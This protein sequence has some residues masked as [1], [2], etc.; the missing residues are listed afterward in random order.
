MRRCG[1]RRRGSGKI[2]MT[3]LPRRVNRGGAKKIT[4]LQSWV[5]RRGGGGR[6]TGAVRNVHRTSCDTRRGD[7]WAIYHRAGHILSAISSLSPGYKLTRPGHD[8]RA[9]GVRLR[10]FCIFVTDHTHTM[11]RARRRFFNRGNLRR[12][13]CNE[14]SID[15]KISPEL[16]EDD[17]RV[18]NGS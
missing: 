2:M 16:S 9:R 10:D 4:R 15:A 7:Q 1:R 13:R 6:G 5:G 3:A 17:L 8:P 12:A 11:L 14:L 18:T